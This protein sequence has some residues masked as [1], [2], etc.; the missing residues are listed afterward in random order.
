VTSRPL[1]TV[2]WHV[3]VGAAEFAAARERAA[4]LQ[5]VADDRVCVPQRVVMHAGERVVAVVPHVEGVSLDA[6]L[7]Q[8]GYLSVG[9]CVGLGVHLSGALATMHARGLAHGEVS[10]AT[11]M[12]TST[13][14]VLLGTVSA[15]RPVDR[16]KR[17]FDSP[18]RSEGPS[19]ASDVYAVGA[20][21]AACV[22]P[23]MR[24][25]FMGWVDPLLELDPP[26][27]PSARAVELGLVKCAD[28]VAILLPQEG[29]VEDLR[30]SRLEPRERT[31]VLRASRPW[32]VRRRVA[33]SA[34]VLVVASSAVGVGVF[35]LAGPEVTAAGSSGVMT[36]MPQAQDVV[37]RSVTTPMPMPQ[38]A[39]R[40]LTDARFSALAAG[41]GQGLLAGIAD[42]SEL[43]VQLGKQAEELDAG[44][45]RFEGVG[46]TI[47]NAEV[48]DAVAPGDA[49][50]TSGAVVSVTYD[51]A[52]HTVWRNE[53][54]TAVAAHR[55]VAHLELVR[56]GT[57]W[58]VARVLP[59][60]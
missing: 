2:D 44:T 30:A 58:R 11:V 5:L 21:L 26:V 50:G 31:L 43:A 8:R 41:D 13:G 17:G 47:V 53:E 14:I 25:S 1:P 60:S 34:A 46:A 12:V 40:E 49:A 38:E 3:G 56:D 51:V 22:A 10:T 57:T 6:L 36:A 27:R 48:M 23:S 59:V 37:V 20:V 32:R 24:Q 28:P 54:R 52:A 4:L 19:K 33:R 55:E 7:R 35:V 15:P 18:E 29:A 45:L 39:A 9:E 42:G 16:V